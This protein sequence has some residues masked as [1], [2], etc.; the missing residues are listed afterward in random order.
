MRARTVSSWILGLAFAL[1]GLNHFRAPAFYLRI[2]PPYL[3]WHAALV[4][5]SGVAELVL[6]LAFCWPP[7]R[8][9]VG[10][11]LVALL[12]AIFPANVHMALH[13]HDFADVPHWALWLR[14][15]LQGALAAWILWS[16]KSGD[17]RGLAN[18]R[19]DSDTTL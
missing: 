7:A 13:P 5:L 17:F 8:R 1:A 10:W 11:G 19:A 12:I 16:A 6:G 4:Q 9:R 3:P 18:K 15:P 14:L 2:M